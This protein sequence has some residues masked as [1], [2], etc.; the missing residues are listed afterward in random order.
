MRELAAIALGVVVACGGGGGGTKPATTT[1]ENSSPVD[2]PSTSAVVTRV[3]ATENEAK[4]TGGVKDAVA[5]R[6]S[7]DKWSGEARSCLIVAN[8]G[9]A[10]HD[11]GYNHLTQAQQDKL[12]K[13]TTPLTSFEME[14]AMRAM[15]KFKDQMCGCKDAKCAQDVADEMTKWSQEMSKS[16]KEPPKMADDDIKR[17]AAIGEEMGRCMQAAM[18]AGMGAGGGSMQGPIA[19]LS[20]TGL[21][22]DRGDPAGGTYVVIKGTTFLAE[23]ARNAKVFF[24]DKQGTVVRFASDDEL[25]VE[26][27]AG[28]TNQT[29]DVIVVFDP[30]GEMKLPKAFTFS[31]AKKKKK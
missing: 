11:C 3:L 15:S 7:E 13:A 17:A 27:P 2:C 9:Q 24:G 16:M 8:T 29:V 14:R 4:D 10:L 12:N 1:P 20:L 19:P 5:K 30:G 28:K 6:C 31:K 22:P 26:A 23:G 25:I 18:S 21:D